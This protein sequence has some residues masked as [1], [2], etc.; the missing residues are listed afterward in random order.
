MS[1]IS[2]PTSNLYLQNLK[3]QHLLI[4]N[5]KDVDEIIKKMSESMILKF[6]KYWDEYSVVLAFGIVLDP[7]M[8]LDSLGY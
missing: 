4:D 2:Y 7:R 1:E 6:G 3:I 5:Q 8:K